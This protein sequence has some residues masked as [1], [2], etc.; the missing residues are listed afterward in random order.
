MINI[1]TP[2][3]FKEEKEYIFHIIFEHTMGIPFSTRQVSD[4][5]YKI[6][7]NNKTLL[8][9]NTFF[10]HEGKEDTYLPLKIPP[11]VKFA[12]NEFLSE[13]DIPVIYG[14]PD[15]KVE[16]NKIYC[17]I[18]II[19]SCFFMLT[20]WE[21]YVC[22]A[23]DQYGRFPVKE[24]LAFKHG[25]LHRPVVNEYIEMLWNMLQR[26]G[27]R[28]ERKKRQ[29]RDIPTHDI[30]KFF[31]PA[32][33]KNIAGDILKGRGINKAMRR[34]RL[35]ETNHYDTFD[36]LMD[37]SEKQGLQSRFY[38]INHP[39]IS[40]KNAD[41]RIDNKM[42][43]ST[44]QNIRQ[45]GHIIGI[46]PSFDTYN[47]PEMLKKEKDSFG[48]HFGLT[49]TEG[50]QHFLRFEVPHTWQNWKECG[51]QIDSTLG[52]AEYS[53]FRCGTADEFPVFNVLTR[54]TLP[55]KERPLI[56]MDATY[57]NKKYQKSG[58]EEV[59]VQFRHFRDICRKYN[60]PF[61]FLF[62][63]SGFNP[64]YFGRWKEMYENLFTQQV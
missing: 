7:I 8:I 56:F 35:R 57:Q 20:R 28:G 46:H 19:A 64:M 31:F 25:F 2:S 30:D 41:Y 62:H 22:K 40:D 54:K 38:F 49:I 14:T 29:F 60:M 10:S 32:K 37:T 39:V 21:E 59:A 50:R 42:V 9:N 34:Y 58:T 48:K 52:Y 17:G 24:A 12:K 5:Y 27:Y 63:N 36:W 23:R 16:E 6:Q 26:L 51:M 15:I 61:T 3:G 4:K 1:K 43:E 44:I 13:T 55:L 47:D 45:R 33:I 18:D 53:G 11:K